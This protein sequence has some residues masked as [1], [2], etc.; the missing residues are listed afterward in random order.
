MGSAWPPAGDA[1]RSANALPAPTRAAQNCGSRSRPG[2]TT[3]EPPTPPTPPRPCRHPCPARAAQHARRL[4]GAWPHAAP[5]CAPPASAAARA[6]HR[7]EHR[8]TAR[9]PRRRS[10]LLRPRSPGRSAHTRG[11]APAKRS[12]TSSS[13]RSHDPDLHQPRPRAHPQHVTKQPGQRRLMPHTKLRD[14]RM[15]RLQ[16][17]SL[18]HVYVR[19]RRWR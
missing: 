4:A 18:S 6:A 12:L 17:L 15:I 10:S 14:R 9:P 7:H 13:H 2:P 19:C 11:C 8:R 5:T 16:L 3:T 1:H